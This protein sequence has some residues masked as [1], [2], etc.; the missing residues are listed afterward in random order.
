MIANNDSFDRKILLAV[1]AFEALL[2]YNFYTREVAWYPP[3]NF[4]QAG[5]LTEAYQLQE[6]FLAHGPD[7]L[8]KYLSNRSHAGGVLFPIE[9]ALS[10]IILGGARFPQ[11]CVLFFAF[12]AFQVAAF[13]T[14]RMVWSSRLFGY[15]A[16]GLTLSQETPWL[17]QGGGLFDFRMDFLAYCLYGI[18][19][20]A[21]IRSRIFLDRYWSIGSGLAGALLV[22]NRFVTL[23]YLL[24]VSAGLAVVCGIFA[25][26]GRHDTELPSRMNC[27]F[28]GLG[29]S[30][31]LLIAIVLPILIRNWNAIHGYYVIGHV[32]GGEKY[33]RAAELGLKDL[34]GHL[35]FYPKSVVQDHLGKIFAWESAIVIACALAARLLASRN[36]IPAKPPQQRDEES[37]LRFAFLIGA[38]LCPIV[39]LTL[40][41]AKS[42]VV[43]GIVGGPAILFVVAITAAIAPKPPWFDSPI[44][45]RILAACTLLICVMGLFNQFSHANRHWPAYAHR[46]DLKH[47]DQLN[48]CLID[49]AKEYGWSSPWISYDVISGWFNAGSPTITAFEKSRDL[50]EFH[51]MLGN[52]IMGVSRKEAVS[53]L[54]NSDFLI[55]TTLPKGGGTLPFDRRIAEY[56]DDLKAWADDNMIVA[57]IVPFSTFSATVYLRPAAT[58]SGLSGGWIPSHG[59][60]IEAARDVLAR[61]PLI[62]LVGSTDYS[63]LQ[64]IP[65]VEAT[66]DTG[67]S[68]QPVPA[69][70]Q[71]ADNFYE[72]RVNTSSMR[73]PPA[74]QVHIRLDFNSFFIPKTTEAGKDA[75]ELVV[76]A[77]VRVQLTRAGP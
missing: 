25:I 60:S 28:R 54:E 46:D 15:I 2:Y 75:P 53:L 4:D 17:R 52:G 61:F 64:K 7:Q 29:I 11:L 68:S 71:R 16:L 49:L 40:D 59:F 41:I 5:Y 74:D 39:V 12:C 72:I 26:F 66:M 57:R 3:D 73:L 63:R 20:C 34:A 8:W 65:T 50:I 1:I 14:A 38:V 24:G 42:A 23:P 31:G 47:L 76:K 48:Q 69:S 55:L 51:P 44:G 45:A 35:T 18:W 62:R 37:L 77:P 6:N 19:V 33:V 67:E 58:I 22:L 43:G 36:N 9:G 10:G 21:V 70:F 27:R 30:T 56:W 32:L 13:T